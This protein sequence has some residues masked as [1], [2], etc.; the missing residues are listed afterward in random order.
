MATGLDCVGNLRLTDVKYPKVF[1]NPT[2]C[3]GIYNSQN[4]KIRLS[5]IVNRDSAKFFMFDVARMKPDDYLLK[6]S[7]FEASFSVTDGQLTLGKVVYYDRRK[8]AKDNATTDATV[9]CSI[10]PSAKEPS[11]SGEDKSGDKGVGEG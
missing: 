2:T 6:D 11:G 10:G 4:K 7:R 1:T 8:E 3:E 9:V 5:H